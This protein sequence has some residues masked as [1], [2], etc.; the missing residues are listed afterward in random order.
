MTYDNSYGRDAVFL[1]IC[2]KRFAVA[3]ALNQH[4][5]IHTGER[6]YFC[7]MCSKR[8]AQAGTL[9]RHMRTHTGER[10]YSCAICSEI[11]SSRRLGE[12]HDNSYW[13]KAVFLCYLFKEVRS[14]VLP[15][16]THDNSYFIVV[17]FFPLFGATLLHWEST[18]NDSY[19]SCLVQNRNVLR[20]LITTGA[21]R[22]L[23]SKVACK[24]CLWRLLQVGPCV[25][26]KPNSLQPFL[27]SCAYGMA[28]LYNNVRDT[29]CSDAACSLLYPYLHH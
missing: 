26:F 10:Q 15:K 27:K 8:F 24:T 6:Q 20:Q 5:T 16:Q 25:V 1:C 9:V 22:S 12:P 4:T 14:S 7:A 2:S 13:R 3:S 28:F 17:W 29:V 21:K 23:T 19:E 11:R 18:H